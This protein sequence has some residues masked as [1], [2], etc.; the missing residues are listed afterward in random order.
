MEFVKSYKGYRI[1]K[2]TKKD[3]PY[4]HT[5]GEYEVQTSD[6][7]QEYDNVESVGMCEELING[8]IEDRRNKQW[9]QQW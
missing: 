9:K 4:G 8:L 2:Y 5:L 6:N 7:R 1:K 3:V